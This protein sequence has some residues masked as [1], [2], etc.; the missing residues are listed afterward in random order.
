DLSKNTERIDSRETIASRQGCDLCAMGNREAIRHDD[1]ATIRFACQC[2]NDGLD[3]GPVAN[4]CCGRLHSKGGSSSFKEFQ[5]IFGICRRFRVEQERDPV[6]VRRN[7]LEQL[8]P[9]AAQRGLDSGETGDVAARP[10]QRRDEAAAD[11]IRNAR[12]NDGDGARFWQQR[13]RGGCR[14][15]KNEAGLQRD[16]FLRELF[17][18]PRVLGRHPARVHPDFVALRPPEL[19]QS[20][21]ES[22]AVGLRFRVALR[23]AHQRPNPPH[24]V[25][26]LRAR[27]ERPRR[28][29]AET[30][31]EI[32]PPHS[33]TSSA[34]NWIELGTSMPSALAVCKL[35]T[36]SNLVDCNTGSSAGFGALGRVPVWKRTRRGTRA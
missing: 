34:S 21:P 29:A 11:R 6:D 20:L 18:W 30:R 8:Q 17:P 3:L 15:R 32:A 24:P 7:L 10:R 33:I 14:M 16:E 5:V 1:K 12:E 28:R 26:L 23:I 13:R 27:R 2:G 31:D 4:R 9:L 36:N 35:M 25:S 19:L 22:R